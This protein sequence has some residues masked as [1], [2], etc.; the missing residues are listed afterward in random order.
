MKVLLDTHVWLWMGLEPGRLSGAASDALASAQNETILSVAS[1]WELAIKQALGNS[2]HLA[3]WT[4]WFGLRCRISADRPGARVRCGRFAADTQGSFRPHVNRASAGG[5]LG[6]S[7]SRRD[8]PAIWWP[9]VMGGL[10][11][12]LLL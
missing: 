4:P 12:S 8:Y 11:G 2:P 9:R 10:I 5:G 3:P 6:P 1:A 7:H